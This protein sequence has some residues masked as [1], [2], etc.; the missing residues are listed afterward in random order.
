MGALF[1]VSQHEEVGLLD[2]TG[3]HIHR[4]HLGNAGIYQGE[5]DGDTNKAP[6]ETSSSA[7]GQAGS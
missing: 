7:I 2:L 5:A 3:S 1:S 6:Y 4:G